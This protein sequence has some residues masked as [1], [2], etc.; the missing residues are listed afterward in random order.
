MN[1][2]RLKIIEPA[3]LELQ[4][5]Y[6]YYEAESTNLGRLFINEFRRGVNRI[7]QFP[8]AWPSI[9]KNIRKCTLKKFPFH[10]IYAVTE[11]LILILAIAHHRRKPDY[12]IDR[13]Q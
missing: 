8:Q 4:D 3:E 9:E 1:R 7:L 11:D 12:W 13:L 10:I 5:I 6:D 2:R